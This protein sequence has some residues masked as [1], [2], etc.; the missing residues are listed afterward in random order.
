MIIG[1]THDKDGKIIKMMQAGGK[2]S[3]GLKPNSK[4]NNCK[5]HPENTGVFRMFREYQENIITKNGPSSVS[6]WELYEPAQKTLVMQNSRDPNNLNIY[7]RTIRFMLFHYDANEMWSTCM[8]AY[9]S[10]CCFCRSNGMG[11]VASRLTIEGSKRGRVNLVCN[12]HECQYYIDKTCKPTGRL[13][14]Y[15]LCDFIP[16]RPYKFE[17]RSV[18][19][20]KSIESALYD[21]WEMSNLAHE[22]YCFLQKDSKIP[23]RGFKFTEFMLKS[24]RMVVGGNET[25]I[26]EVYPTPEAIQRERD[27]INRVIDMYKSDPYGVPLFGVNIEVIDNKPEYQEDV[28]EVE[29]IDGLTPKQ[30]KLFCDE[31]DGKKD[32]DE[33]DDFD[34]DIALDEGRMEEQLLE[35]DEVVREV[36]KGAAEAANKLLE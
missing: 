16:C 29:T 34:A 18:V 31:F 19:T 27:P 9:K 26:V 22:M 1:I 13:F 25:Y 35:S 4:I 32:E 2:V 17:T 6:R 7:P 12:L 11:T 3:I 24:R 23:F 14:L 30:Q 15:P 33:V 28:L 5:N 36:E 10:K 21:M 8:A 20:V